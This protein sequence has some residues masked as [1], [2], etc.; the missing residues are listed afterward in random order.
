MEKHQW[1]ALITG[2]R[3]DEDPTRAKE[4]YFS[5]RNKENQWDYKDQPPEFWNQFN[6]NVGPGEHVRVQA[7][8]DWSEVDIWKYIK[9]EEIPIPDLYFAR[10]GKRFRSLGDWPITHPVESNASTID[11]IIEELNSTKTSERS[12]R[13]QDHHERNAMQKLRAKGFM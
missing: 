11:E 10:E 8:L 12:G 4:R 9:R 7:L 2:I 3:R 5:P 6:T 1:D 13:A